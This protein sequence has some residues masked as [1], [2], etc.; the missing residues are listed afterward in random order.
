M[1]S[2]VQRWKESKKKEVLKGGGSAVINTTRIHE[3]RG[4]HPWPCSVG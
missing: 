2:K 3:D 1:E 4:F